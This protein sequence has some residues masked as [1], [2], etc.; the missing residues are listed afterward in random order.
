MQA[1]VSEQTADLYIYIWK[2][3]RSMNHRR[4]HFLFYETTLNLT[5]S[6]RGVDVNL[7]KKE[8]NSIMNEGEMAKHTVHF[9]MCKN[10]LD[11]MF[12]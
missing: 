11:S 8:R 5:M 6:M 3:K 7:W 4:I 2:Q 1:N 9:I 10:Q 12:A